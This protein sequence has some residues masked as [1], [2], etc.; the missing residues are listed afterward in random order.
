MKVGE[1]LF[2]INQRFDYSAVGTLYNKHPLATDTTLFTKDLRTDYFSQEIYDLDYLLQ[3]RHLS[4]FKHF[5]ANIP[6]DTP[7]VLNK[8]KSLKRLKGQTYFS[9]LAPYLL[10]HGKKGHSIN[11]ITKSLFYILT[12]L[13]IESTSNRFNPSTSW[14]NMYF[15]LNSL[16]VNSSFA[17]N[18]ILFLSRANKLNLF[19]DNKVRNSEI[20]DIS[21]VGFKQLWLTSLKKFRY[22]FSFYVYKVD[23]SI[24]KNSRGKSGKFTFVWKYVAPYKRSL[25]ISHWLMKEVRI[26]PG[27]TLQ[28]RVNYIIAN[29]LSS[30]EKTWVW[31]INKFSLNYVYYN[32]RNSLAETCRTSMR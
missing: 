11:L 30:P 21:E 25:L 4:S 19:Y 13:K 1:H 17:A 23:K 31:K 22:L 2:I 6:I 7:A 12:S 20:I 26:S 32:L 10:R 15:L 14:L 5:F 16:T 24:Y 3:D 9:K 27:K 28:D 18:T 29:F 8:T